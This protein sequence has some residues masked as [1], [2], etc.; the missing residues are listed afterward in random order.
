MLVTTPDAARFGL[1]GRRDLIN[2]ANY[3]RLE[4]SKGIDGWD[5]DISANE[6]KSDLDAKADFA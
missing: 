6:F 1:T 2:S 3:F 5:N 4:V